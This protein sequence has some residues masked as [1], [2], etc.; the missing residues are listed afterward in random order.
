MN[1]FVGFVVAG[2][3]L[4]AIKALSWAVGAVE[5]VKQSTGARQNTT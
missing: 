2:R 1:T 4:I 3:R 5:E